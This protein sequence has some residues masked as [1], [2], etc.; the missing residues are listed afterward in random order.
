MPNFY[1]ILTD[2]L[3]G[4][5]T[6]DYNVPVAGKYVMRLALAEEGLNATYFNSTDFG[7]LVDG[8][9]NYEAFVL[10]KQGRPLNL[11]SSI[12]W[13][14]DLG[15][16]PGPQAGIGEGTY[17]HRY[18]TR[19]ERQIACD[20]RGVDPDEYFGIDRS[21]EDGDVPF[22]FRD[23]YWSARWTGR[24][25][26]EKA[27]V[28]KFS[29]EIDDDSTLLVRI[30]GR[31]LEFNNSQP[32][33]ILLQRDR[34]A[35]VVPTA[36]F[37]FTEV[38]PLELLVE[39]AHFTGDAV[40]KLYWE[41]LST[42]RTLIPPSAFTHWRNV[43]HYNTTIHPA[44]LCSSCSTAVGAALHDARVAEKK[45]FWV[46]AR[47]EFGN[48]LQRGG[49]V[50][51]M[52]A[53]GPTGVSIRGEVTDYG[54]STYLIDYY[55]AEAG[56]FLMYVTIGCCP[57][58]PDV[59]FPSEMQQFRHLLISG[60]PFLLKVMPAPLNQSTTI[61]TGHGLSGGI[62][63][64]PLTFITFYRDIH[65]NPTTVDNVSESHLITRFIDTV[66]GSEVRPAEIHTELSVGGAVTTY[67]LTQA[68]SYLLHVLLIAGVNDT[69]EE[70]KDSPFSVLMIPN[71]ADPAHTVCRGVGLRQAS[72]NMTASMEIQLF[73]RFRNNLIIGGDKFWIRLQGDANFSDSQL[74]VIPRCEDTQNGRYIC[75]YQPL[76][77]GTHQ[78]A[79]IHL[80]SSV[81][82]MGGLGLT[83]TYYAS[84]DGATDGR[85]GVRKYSAAP[86]YTRID[87]QVKFRW[88]QGLVVPV[89][90]LAVTTPTA[91]VSSSAAVVPVAAGAEV[92][93]ADKFVSLE[94]LPLRDA[95]QSVRWDGY[96]IAP[97]G[98]VYT[99]N[100]LVVN[101][102]A[103]VYLDDRLVYDSRDGVAPPV[104]LLLGSAYEIRVLAR[105]RYTVPAAKD[106]FTSPSPGVVSID[107]RWSTP[108]VNEYSIPQVFL[109]DSGTEIA[110]SPFPVLVA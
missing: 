6:I 64:F 81:T 38:K 2:N 36:W 1:G 42:P 86:A 19:V 106:V 31:G 101:M 13:T 43:S 105:T 46:Y 15:R 109:F 30:G 26:P 54:N 103:Q 107:L 102:E 10:A 77:A 4:R 65:D 55:P 69:M 56:E 85:R 82:P 27:E 45:S 50:P 22:K 108:T 52:V 104:H 88:A 33:E 29:A 16:R 20:F 24:I 84:F 78:L 76:Y 90:D 23:E 3:D 28:Y 92:D 35:A 73:D 93:G 110:F 75:R 57:P 91:P 68:G 11:G 80:N 48:L 67:S 61:A 74:D 12:S 41:S 34:T 70:I 14:G 98:D 99:F 53:V 95:G 7:Y 97:R 40:L 17:F 49:D 37:N 87:P 66:T 59:G 89:D 32:G 83:A 44:P 5:Y 58:H 71:E 18:A 72:L 94:E 8:D 51:S 60:A 79:I 39:F 9:Y 100:A 21:T 96:L 47:D 25:T 62:V 63:G